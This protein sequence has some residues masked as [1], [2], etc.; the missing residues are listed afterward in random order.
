MQ[1]RIDCYDKNRDG[2]KHQ[3]LT[4]TFQPLNNAGTIPTTLFFVLI[5]IGLS[6]EASFKVQ[7]LAVNSK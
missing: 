2:S 1:N 7:F 4:F 5:N 6:L 3:I